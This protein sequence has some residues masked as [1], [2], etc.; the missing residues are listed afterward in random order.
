M[1]KVAAALN[2]AAHALCICRRLAGS[3]RVGHDVLVR[4]LMEQYRE[5]RPGA[6]SRNVLKAS[7]H[8]LAAETKC[9]YQA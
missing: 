2:N 7:L 1:A 9:K 5:E 3:D 6:S 4:A 8:G